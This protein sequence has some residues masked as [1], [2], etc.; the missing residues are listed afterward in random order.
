[1]YNESG[2]CSLIKN[3]KLSSSLKSAERLQIRPCS[4]L[5]FPR[6]SG[7]NES[8]RRASKRKAQ[9]LLS[10]RE[11]PSPSRWPL[12]CRSSRERSFSSV[13]T[14][15][16]GSA[17]LG[18]GRSGRQEDDPSFEKLILAVTVRKNHH[19]QTPKEGQAQ[20][21]LTGVFSFCLKE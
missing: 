12:A 13:L 19:N 16:L 15:E 14:K 4:A 21:R 11:P 10:G 3:D 6:W 17:G 9:C 1:M 18:L 2:T 7:G 5:Q 20:T 8:R